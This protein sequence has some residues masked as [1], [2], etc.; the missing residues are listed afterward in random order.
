[1]LG[2]HEGTGSQQILRGGAVATRGFSRLFGLA[3][4]FIVVSCGGGG[5]SSG[6][7]SSG[8][9]SS[10]GSSSGAQAS[11]TAN[12]QTVNAPTG[13]L[14]SG[15]SVTN[16]K[17]LVNYSPLA[18]PAVGVAVTDPDFGV[19]I[20]RITDAQTNW[21]MNVAVP[22]YPTIAAWN[23]DESYLVL[24]AT[25]NLANSASCPANAPG[26]GWALFNGKTY[27]FI[28][29]L[30][31]N[32]ADIEQFYWD[33]SN[34]DVM[35]Y[36]D[37]TTMVLTSFS[38]S[39]NAP[40]AQLHNFANDVTNGGVLASA[41]NYQGTGAPTLVS[42]GE[43][44]FFMSQN[45]DLIG[46]GCATNYV[47]PASGSTDFV[48]FTY[49]IST[50]TISLPG[51]LAPA[52]VP[53]ATP[54]GN[55]AWFYGLTAPATGQV[56][57]TADNSVVRSVTLDGTQHSD[58]LMNAAGQDVVGAAQYDGPGDNGSLIIANLDTGV[59]STIIGGN[60]GDPYPPSGTLISGR[61]TQAPGWFGVSATGNINVVQTYLDQEVMLVNVDTK[62]MCRVAHHRSTGNWD[63]ATISNYWAQPNATTSPSGTRILFASD[64]GAGTPGNSVTA[65]PYAVVDT[66]VIELPGYVP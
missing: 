51:I 31:I 59:V 27:Q 47:D 48:G 16:S 25:C 23:A 52:V 30:A 33:H 58:M 36:V 8:G 54:S 53:Q 13:G 4:I 10:G 45:N 24:Y 55:N 18:K 43:D 22:A 39:A 12:P 6:G 44:P 56:L 35:Y 11:A 57:S 14:C 61:A 1:M 28:K 42:G 49:R 2:L 41:C 50:N 5:S 17:V 21:S 64:W 46:L 7:S 37:A 66:Y 38:V 9:S 29:W 32:P 62:E 34:A 60:T 63:N 19:T 15:V 3:L 65:S 26:P 20:R 40:L